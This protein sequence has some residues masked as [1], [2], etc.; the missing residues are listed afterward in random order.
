M[1]T[2]FLINSLGYGGA[3]RVFINDANAFA[4]TGDIVLFFVLYGSRASYPQVAEFDPR[5]RL[6]FLSARNA[7]DMWA[8]WRCAKELREASVGALVSTLNDANIFARWVCLWMGRARPRCILREANTLSSK[9]SW[10]RALDRLCAKIPD[11]IIAIS[12]DIRQS[13]EKEGFREKIVFI[14]NAVETQ[15]LH[16]RLDNNGFRILAVGSL[17]AQK[18]HAT[19]ISALGMLARI[20]VQFTATIIGQ[21]SLQE[22]LQ[23]HVE[24]EGIV[25]KVRFS[26]ALPHDAVLREYE[27]ADVFVLSSRWEGSPNTVLE[28]MA[29]G[30]PVVATHVGGVSDFV[31]D[32]ETGILVQPG[33]PEAISRALASLARDPILRSDMGIAGRER[34]SNHFSVEAR[35]E[36][37]RGIVNST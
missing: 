14:P 7:F 21:G 37:L 30:L 22:T 20:G 28:A 4:R 15:G 12:N 6:I 35:F 9:V 23:A 2:A 1:T 24:R 33:E 32:Q 8:V 27:N 13:L 34:V 19:L 36:R 16:E 26:G 3:E 11:R 17:T 10:Q 18:D 25:E 29:A 31:L 5:V